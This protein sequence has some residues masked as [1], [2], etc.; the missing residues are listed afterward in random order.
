MNQFKIKGICTVFLLFILFSPP[1]FSYDLIV[2]DTGQ[3][4]CYDWTAIIDC[5]SEGEDFYGQDGSYTINPPDLTDNGDGTVTDNITGLIWEQ[6]TE[7]N[8]TYAYTYSNAIT[9][10]AELILGGSSDWRVPTRKEYSTI[11]NFGRV[12]PSLDIDYFP[13]YSYLTEDD[14]DHWTTS[15]YHDDT[16]QV[17]KIFISFGLI[18]KGPKTADPPMLNKVRC[19]QG[20]PEPVT[21]YTD[22]G[23]GTVT[24]NVTG[25]MWEQKTDEGGCRNKDNTYT[26]KDALSYCENLLLAGYSDWKLP[27]PKELERIVDLESSS[28]AIDTT[29]FP[30]TNNGLYWTGTT[31]SGCHKMKAFAIDFE[32]GELYYGNKYRNYVYGENYVRCVGNPGIDPDE[33]GISY[34]DDNCPY[35]YNPLQEDGD[36]D[37]YGNVCDNCPSDSNSNQEDAD[38]DR[39]GDLCDNCTE[40]PNS[41]DLGTCTKIVSGLVL[42]TGVICTDD[43]HCAGETCQKEQGDCN[44]NGIG[45][46]C[47]CYADCNSD[48]K[49]ELQDL[50][51]MKGEFGRN[52]CDTNPCQADSNDDDKVDLQD[53][54]IMKAEFGSTSCPVI[55]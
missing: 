40:K 7:V 20:D 3:D 24:D 5:P 31:C 1:V 34:P 23:D 35:T 25:L 17:W 2:P 10:C 51:I 49:V 32:D 36:G 37:E 41:S 28:P 18:E 11:L 6:K 27:N 21:S 33:D 53:L 14:M 44:G 55:P 47:E 50:V 30:N 38:C 42:G 16:S 15:E 4:L 39:I 9:Y 29:Y 45:D 12:N 8:E 43:E 19:V 48:T 46:V 13:Y 26:W 52:D 54:V 22:N